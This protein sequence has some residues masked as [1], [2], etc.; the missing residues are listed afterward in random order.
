MVVQPLVGDAEAKG[1]LV[2]ERRLGERDSGGPEIVR[3]V[4]DQLVGTAPELRAGKQRRAGAA[5]R[6]GDKGLEPLPFPPGA[7]R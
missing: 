6:V 5:V 7:K 1:D 3:G 4:E 2:Q